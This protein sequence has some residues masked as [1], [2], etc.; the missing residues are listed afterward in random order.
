MT[1]WD[2]LALVG[3]QSCPPSAGSG[4]DYSQNGETAI[5]RRI[6]ELV[7]ETNR[8]AVE[9]GAGD[10]FSLSNTR[11]F[12]Q[13]GWTSRMFDLQAAA[14][15][16]AERITSENVDDVFDKYDVPARF[17]LLS[18]DVDGNDYWIW[19]A[20]SRH[21]PRVV[22]IEFN[23][24]FGSDTLATV[25]NEPERVYADTDYYGASFGLLVALGRAK[26]YEPVLSHHGVNLFFV[27]RELVTDPP[28]VTHTAVAWHTADPNGRSWI[29]YD[30]FHPLTEAEHCMPGEATP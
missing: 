23:G 18:I 2:D 30:S 3:D 15:V 4:P 8:F 10:G 12:V 24:L 26:G 14:D 29:F 11:G 17:D 27:S 16:H 20:L 28:I 9:F 19:R 21:R 6:F 13:T 25:P 7:G 5:L 22:V 1:R